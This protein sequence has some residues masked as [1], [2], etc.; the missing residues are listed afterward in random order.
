MLDALLVRNVGPGPTTMVA[1]GVGKQ[2]L[3]IRSQSAKLLTRKRK[4]CVIK[5]IFY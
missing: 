3:A 5:V 1:S 2:M 4:L